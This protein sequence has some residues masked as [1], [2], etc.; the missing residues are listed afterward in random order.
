MRVK[1]GDNVRVHY[2]GRLTDGTTFDSSV[3]REPLEYIV[4]DGLVIPG[5]EEGVLSW[6]WEKRKQ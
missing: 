4:G 5:F 3:G 6:I 1:K 2:Q